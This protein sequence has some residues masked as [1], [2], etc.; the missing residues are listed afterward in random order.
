MTLPNQQVVGIY[1]VCLVDKLVRVQANTG[2]SWD[3]IRFSKGWC[4]TQEGLHLVWWT[5]SPTCDLVEVRVLIDDNALDVV[6]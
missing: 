1:L 5:S 2:S 3:D 6:D 4:G